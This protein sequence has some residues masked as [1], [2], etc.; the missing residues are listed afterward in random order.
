MP[1]GTDFNF[2]WNTIANGPAK[3]KAMAR[4]KKGKSRP[5]KPFGTVRKGG[6]GGS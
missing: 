6:F 2:G 3:T 5:R 4:R 1:K